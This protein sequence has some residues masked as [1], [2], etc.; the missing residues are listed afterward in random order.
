V[1]C[2]GTKS[3]IYPPA[4]PAPTQRHECRHC[5]GAPAA[6]ALY[7]SP[8]EPW[9]QWLTGVQGKPPVPYYDPMEFTIKEAHKR[10]FEYHAW[11]NPYRANFSM[12]KASIAPAHITR[13]HP[14]W[15]LQYGNTLYFDPGNKE[16]Q[17]WVVDVIPIW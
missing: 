6:D 14:K 7:P 9:S 13:L 15:F 4:R 3:R 1:E 5:A 8:Y 17:H 2:G 16:A 12:G 10:G 11:V